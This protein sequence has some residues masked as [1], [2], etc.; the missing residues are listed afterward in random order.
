MKI[1]H[2][3][4]IQNKYLKNSKNEKL[5]YPRDFDMKNLLSNIIQNLKI[6]KYIF[7]SSSPKGKSSK[8]CPF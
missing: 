3:K 6:L 4:K 2:F 1:G 8:E 7:E 5:L